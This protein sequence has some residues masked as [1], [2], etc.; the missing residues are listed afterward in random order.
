MATQEKQLNGEINIEV[1]NK[2]VSCIENALN[3]SIKSGVFEMKECHTIYECFTGITELVKHCDLMQKK[4]KQMTQY[5]DMPKVPVV[6]MEK[7]D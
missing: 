4:L 3:R 1:V 7:Q 2:C 5:Q 6:G